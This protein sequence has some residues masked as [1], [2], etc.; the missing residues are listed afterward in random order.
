MNEAP[1]NEA[2]KA[3]CSLFILIPCLDYIFEV[4][5]CSHDVAYETSLR[6]SHLL[7]NWIMQ[8]VAL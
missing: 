3:R 5:V 7:P 1:K 6:A 8:T 2:V 4:N